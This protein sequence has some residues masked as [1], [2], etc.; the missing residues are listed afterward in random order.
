MS[1]FNAAIAEV[2][3][4]EMIPAIEEYVAQKHSIQLEKS[5][6][7]NLLFSGEGGSSN[8]RPS[9]TKKKISTNSEYKCMY[10]FV[11]R[12]D[13]PARDCNKPCAE[14]NDRVLKYCPGCCKKPGVLKKESWRN[15]PL[16]DP[17]VSVSESCYLD[18]MV[19]LEKVVQEYRP[20]HPDEVIE[21][22]SITFTPIEGTDYGYIKFDGVVPIVQM[23]GDDFEIFYYVLE[24]DTIRDMTD[25]E[26]KIISSIGHSFIDGEPK[27]E[28]GIK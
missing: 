25:D 7:E 23:N 4:N 15:S 14:H 17:N 9:R 6:L 3:K 21:E 26:I 22:E 16:F 12:K 1:S 20:P 5:E 28:N 13:K 2:I 8:K 18:K 24:D 11:A 10:A 27:I 19:K